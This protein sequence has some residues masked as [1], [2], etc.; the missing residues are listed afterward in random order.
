MVNV[1]GHNSLSYL[2]SYQNNT[3]NNNEGFAD[4][5]EVAF[6]KYFVFDLPENI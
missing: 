5:A 6:I 4:L 3:V 2:I 1:D